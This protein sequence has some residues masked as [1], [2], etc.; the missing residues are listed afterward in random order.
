MCVL[1][2][3]GALYSDD[4]CSD[5][6]IYHQIVILIHKVCEDIDGPINAKIRQLLFGFLARDI[7]LKHII[8]LCTFVSVTFD[9]N[10]VVVI[11]HSVISL[12]DEDFLMVFIYIQ[13]N[14]QSVPNHFSS[15]M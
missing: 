13:C 3:R 8:I 7:I 10:E 15:F 5:K 2:P 1:V 4:C 14:S 12:R 9:N 6:A 11:F